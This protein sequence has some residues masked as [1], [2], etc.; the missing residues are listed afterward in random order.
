MGKIK[1]TGEEAFASYYADIFGDR[2]NALHHALLEPKCTAAR[3]NKFA[4]NPQASLPDHHKAIPSIPNTFELSS[5]AATVPTHLP[6]PFYLMDP[7]SILAARALDVQPD[8]TVLDMCAAPGGKSL[9]L[10]EGLSDGGT[11]T[12]N[13]LSAA[14][15]RRLKQVL[16]AYLPDSVHNRVHTTGHDATRWCLHQ[17]DAF[18][19]ILLDVPCSSE[20]HVLGDPKALK[21]WSPARSKNL[22]Y[23]Q[24]AILASALQV[25]RPGGRIVY[26]TC[27]LSPQENDGVVLKLKKK[28]GDRYRILKPESTV[29]ESTECGTQ[30]L[31]DISGWGPIYFAVLERL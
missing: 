9:I 7:A 24:Y 21:E 16:R 1:I 2:W 31:P 11:L 20:R 27:A 8:D 12:A 29:G 19:R 3:L 5:P 15:R 10:A 25:V 17:Q 23:R 18:D 28:Y 6:Q 30:L 26:S 13:E 4:E 22:T 14:R